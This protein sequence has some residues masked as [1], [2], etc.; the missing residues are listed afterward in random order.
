MD[1]RRVKQVCEY[2]WKDALALSQEEG[3]TKSRLSI[4]LDILHCFF[5]YNVWSNQYKKEKLHLLK[6]EQKKE[7]CLKYQEKNNKRDKWV[8]EFFDNYK[9]LNKWS[10]FKYERSADLQAKR[11]TAYKKQYGLGENCFVGYDVIFHKHHYVDST[12][13]TG[14]NCG[15]SEHVDIDYT[16]GLQLGNNAWISEGAK[17]LTHNHSI[18]LESKGLDKGCI[19]TPLVIHDGAWVGTRAIIMPG[20]KEIGRCAIISADSHVHTKIPPYSIVLGNPAKIVGF[21]GTPEEIIKHEIETYPKEERIPLEVLEKN[22]D[23]YFL[24]RLKEIKQFTKL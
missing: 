12:I 4:F 15:F 5:K 6:G 10:G 24:Q 18:G 13:V 2:G 20:V 3:A 14:D 9:F 16:G 11:R 23:K 1:F 7:V 8:K 21:R 19:L 22:Y 17:V